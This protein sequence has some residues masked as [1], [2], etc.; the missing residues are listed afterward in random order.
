MLREVWRQAFKTRT[1]SIESIGDHK[2]GYYSLFDLL[3]VGVGATVGSGVFV[4]TGQVAHETTGPA[5]MVAWLIAGLACCLSA[6]AYAELTCR[7]PSAGSAYTYVYATL[8]EWPAVLTAWALSLECGISGASVARSWGAKVSSLISSSQQP[9][10]GFNIYACLLMFAVVLVFLRGVEVSKQTVNVFTAVKTIVVCFMICAAWVFFQRSNLT[11]FMPM[12]MKGVMRGTTT[13][14]FGF[15]GYDEVCCLATETRNPKVDLPRAIFGTIFIAALLYAFSSLALVGMASYEALDSENS[16]YGAFQLLQQPLLAN[17]VAIGEL[18]TMPLVVMASFLP[19]PRILFALARDG[20][21]PSLLAVRSPSANL[22]NAIAFAGIICIIVAGCVPYT[23]LNNLVSGGV[24]LS[25]NLTNVSLVLL[26]RNRHRYEPAQEPAT[27]LTRC[28]GL[29]ILYCICACA[30]AVAWSEYM[31]SSSRTCG[32]L[33]TLLMA[34]LVITAVLIDFTCPPVLG[35]NNYT[36]KSTVGLSEL[37]EDASY[38]TP[39]VPYTPLAAILLN[40]YL[41]AQLQAVELISM[42]SFFAVATVLY[43]VMVCWRIRSSYALPESRTPF[44]S[45]NTSYG[46]LEMHGA[47]PTP[48]PV[49]ARTLYQSA[50]KVKYERLTEKEEDVHAQ[51]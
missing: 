2:G 31:S 37:E 10:T 20:L 45:V 46:Y 39:F 11:P 38:R 21:C 47:T 1:P 4:V 15:I 28:E 19:Q 34:V 41:I 50:V 25:L 8:G 5:V 14:F 6:M 29:L 36:T 30:A 49:P 13:C 27:A 40:T 16:F 22:I 44:S 32:A 18:G 24:L 51:S 3:C 9:D 43:L 26:R 33:A 23:V 12:G 42:L 35:N 7:W 17:L 48:S